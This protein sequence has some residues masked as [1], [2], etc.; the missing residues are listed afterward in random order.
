[1]KK[2]FIFLLAAFMLMV[3]TLHIQA[4]QQKVILHSWS[5]PEPDKAVHPLDDNNDDADKPFAIQSIKY[6]ERGYCSGCEV[7]YL[8]VNPVITYTLL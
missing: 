6:A 4:Q 7:Y 2:L 3:P 5:E 8:I 1:M